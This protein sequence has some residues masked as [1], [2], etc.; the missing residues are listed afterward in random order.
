VLS[1]RQQQQ[2]QRRLLEEY[3][4]LA[5]VELA[6]AEELELLL[7][8]FLRQQQL[9]RLSLRLMLQM[10]RQET[11]SWLLMVKKPLRP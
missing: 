1:T 9:Q 4:V 2:P 5:K 3:P 6:V 11:E 7:R 10:H 8:P